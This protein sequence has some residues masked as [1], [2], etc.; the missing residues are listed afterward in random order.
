MIIQNKNKFN[1]ASLILSNIWLTVLVVV[2]VLLCT[3]LFVQTKKLIWIVLLIPLVVFFVVS[4][5][6]SK[7][8][9]DRFNIETGYNLIRTAITKKADVPK[10]RITIT[11]NCLKHKKDFII[12]YKIDFI[13][14]NS[15]TEESQ[16]LANHSFVSFI[17]YLPL[18]TKYQLKTTK[19]KAQIPAQ[20]KKLN[21]EVGN[22][23]KLNQYN[24]YLICST[25]DQ[26]LLEK[27]L[28]Y[29]NNSYLDSTQLLVEELVEVI[30]K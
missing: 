20:F 3:L 13:D 17:D 24:Y 8:N 19:T 14:L 18:G 12:G 4:V 11:N 9:K 28:N 25:N 23:N 16:E 29:I 27:I 21:I 10:E 26:K 15:Y 1:T 22:Y 2:S 5:I 7:K 6:A 30:T